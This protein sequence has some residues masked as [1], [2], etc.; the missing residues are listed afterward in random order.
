MATKR[1]FIDM[2]GNFLRPIL[3]PGIFVKLK[4]PTRKLLCNRQEFFR[5]KT[6]TGEAIW[7]KHICTN[8]LN[9]NH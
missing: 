4:R 7:L 5:C 1:L 3:P 9:K 6:K 2:M 8:N